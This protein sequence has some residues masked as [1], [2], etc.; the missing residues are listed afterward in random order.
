MDPKQ[1][2]MLAIA[3]GVSAVVVIGLAV[4]LFMQTGKMSEAEAQ[5][6]MNEEMLTGYYSQR[7]TLDKR[8]GEMKGAYP[9]KANLDVR[10]AD[11]EAY[12]VV[13]ER[14]RECLAH[15]LAVPQGESPSQFVTRIGAV[16]RAMNERQEALKRETA[17]KASAANEPMKD[18]SFGRYVVNG[19][20]PAAE[21][22]PRLANQFAV[23]Q[24]VCELLLDAGATNIAQVTRQEFDK[25]VQAEPQ[26]TTRRGR[27]AKKEEAPKEAGATA[28]DPVLVKD[29]VTCESYSVTFDAQYAALVP[30]L[31]QLST[32][33]LF[34]VI[35]DVA[36]ASSFDLP[37]IQNDKIEAQKNA[38][39]KRSAAKKDAKEEPVD[40]SDVA[41]VNRMLI[42]PERSKP[43][44]VTLKFDV[45]SVPPA[46]EPEAEATEAVT[47]GE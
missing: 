10:K 4:V 20:I 11:A 41:V 8:S 37:K 2:M 36:I 27:R 35:T 30:V 7:P 31:N 3:G 28:V 17:T 42:D 12:T 5:R 38:K 46:E 22:V 14:A 43:L 15:P 45:Y 34:V 29:G 6:N 39:K 16:V 44:H 47:E 26:Q 33:E 40:M 13:A 32:E 25:V 9:S 24:H 21:N 18:Y 1:K 23:I 19:E